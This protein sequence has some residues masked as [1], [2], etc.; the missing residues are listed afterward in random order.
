MVVIE[1]TLVSHHLK[2]QART[3]MKNKPKREQCPRS[4]FLSYLKL[5]LVIP[6][7]GAREI[8]GS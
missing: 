3:T 6:S 2:C 4:F 8:P 1:S 5:T 7:E